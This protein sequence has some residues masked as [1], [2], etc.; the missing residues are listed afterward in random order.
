MGIVALGPVAARAEDHHRVAH[1]N[2]EQLKAFLIAD[3]PAK[4]E[5]S[6]FWEEVF[7][8]PTARQH[9]APLIMHDVILA[10]LAARGEKFSDDLRQRLQ[11]DFPGGLWLWAVFGRAHL[12]TAAQRHLKIHGSKRTPFPYSE[13]E[14][15]SHAYEYIKIYMMDSLPDL[16]LADL[17]MSEDDYVKRHFPNFFLESSPESLND[18]QKRLKKKMERELRLLGAAKE[19]YLAEYKLYLLIRERE[20]A[21]ANS[22]KEV[23][24]HW[25]ETVKNALMRAK[26]L[27]LRSLIAANL[28][29]ASTRDRR[30]VFTAGPR[31]SPQINASLALIANATISIAAPTA[32]E[33]QLAVRDPL[34]QRIRKTALNF[35]SSSFRKAYDSKIALQKKLFQDTHQQL[36][37]LASKSGFLLEISPADASKHALGHTTPNQGLSFALSVATFA[38]LITSLSLPETADGFATD[39]LT[40]KYAEDAWQRNHHLDEMLALL[41]QADTIPD[42][43]TRIAR[44][45][46]EEAK[47]H[48]KDK[49]QDP[50]ALSYQHAFTIKTLSHETPDALLGLYFWG[51]SQH[52]GFWR[53]RDNLTAHKPA[54]DAN[55]TGSA[56]RWRSLIPWRDY[57]NAKRTMQWRHLSSFDIGVR[58][59]WQKILH[60]TTLFLTAGSITLASWYGWQMAHMPAKDE[61]NNP[62]VVQHSA[63]RVAL[64]NDG[65]VRP[66]NV[67]APRSYPPSDFEI[68]TSDHVELEALPQRFIL[69]FANDV[70]E[71]IHSYLSP[72][73]K[74]SPPD[75]A[76][77]RI[78][79][80]ALKPGNLGEIILLLPEMYSVNDMTVYWNEGQRYLTRKEF[81]PFGSGQFA[82]LYIKSAAMRGHHFDVL[83]GYKPVAPAAIDRVVPVHDFPEGFDKRPLETVANQLADHGAEDLREDLRELIYATEGAK[84]SINDLSKLLVDAHSYENDADPFWM[85]WQ[86]FDWFAP[87]PSKDFSHWER[88][89]RKKRFQCL[90]A[91]TFFR[92]FVHSFNEQQRL[93]SRRMV[94]DAPLITGLTRQPDS[95]KIFWRLHAWNKLNIHYLLDD[96]TRRLFTY[97]T[98]VDITPLEAEV[99]SIDARP[100]GKDVLAYITLFHDLLNALYTVSEQS[101][102]K[103]RTEFEI[104]RLAPDPTVTDEEDEPVKPEPKSND[105]LADVTRLALALRANE[106]LAKADDD[107]ARTLWIP[108]ALKIASALEAYDA[109]QGTL[110]AVLSA[111][112][113][114]EEQ[115]RDDDASIVKRLEEESLRA[116]TNYKNLCDV[117]AQL[118]DPRRDLKLKDHRPTY[119]SDIVLTREVKELWRLFSELNWRALASRKMP[120]SCEQ[121]FDVSAPHTQG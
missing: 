115:L 121:G 110:L 95:E 93:Y 97:S 26:I 116:W 55:E 100:S 78:K 106:A 114:G 68:D 47:A 69:P 63:Q 36:N 22:S 54:F 72:G 19:E 62:I 120:L 6:R 76:A 16:T 13:L 113:D 11:K 94:F 17:Q 39:P 60:R 43:L 25:S 37:S 80:K 66:M 24:K 75:E 40:A 117:A 28:Q 119:F 35:F 96:Q 67:A 44:L 64:M 102:E 77:F 73:D 89:L 81:I 99:R 118:T 18:E 29:Q 79:S 105:A 50:A 12:E 31:Q 49:Q 111:F 85:N 91:A 20:Q 59:A 61:Q 82:A 8:S 9:Y 65:M 10:A 56:F 23:Y 103:R 112:T 87:K 30:L 33:S 90:P 57:F 84:V 4:T 92:R 108:R 48:A 101:A 21:R 52:Y 74:M 107:V 53:I 104:Q 1:L 98:F 38:K 2:P 46:A 41:N 70:R 7:A 14:A 5:A 86:L 32:D 58:D 45:T 88:F 34:A 109:G 27:N 42:L 71:H 83:V 15:R 3:D 51:K